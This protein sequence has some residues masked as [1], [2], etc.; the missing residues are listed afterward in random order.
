MN[1]QSDIIHF[2]E[3]A[4]ILKRGWLT[5]LLCAVLGL[6]CALVVTNLKEPVY[7]ARAELVIDRTQGADML[8]SEASVFRTIDET[9][10]QTQVRVLQSEMLV[11]RAVQGLLGTAQDR[12]GSVDGSNESDIVKA[13]IRHLRVSFVPRTRIFVLETKSTDATFAAATAN[14]IASTFAEHITEI[15]ASSTEKVF[16]RL[17]KQAEELSSKIKVM[18]NDLVEF[19]HKS[20]VELMTRKSS[21][22]EGLTTDEAADLSESLAMGTPEI[23]E[24]EDA[25][26]TVRQDVSELEKRYKSKHPKMVALSAEK[27]RLEEQVD[28][29]KKRAFFRWQRNHLVERNAVEFSV[30]ER[31]LE[32]TRRLHELIL[33]KI[34]ELDFSKSTPDVSVR[35]LKEA[36]TPQRPAYPNK[37]VNLSLGAVSG[38]II[39]LLILF[40]RIQASHN[41]VSLGTPAKALPASV[42]ARLPQVTSVKRL[43]DIVCGTDTSSPEA[44]AF[45]ALRT[46][47]EAM[48]KPGSNVVLITSPDRGDGKS[49]VSAALAHSFAM[50]GKKVLLIDADLRRGKLHKLLDQ[51]PGSGMVEILQGDK[52]VTPI[53]IVEN[54]FFIPRGA[55]TEQPSELIVSP[56][57]EELML[58]VAESHYIVILD[59][60]PVL[61]VTDAS[62][63]ARYADSKLMVLRS[64]RSPVE[65]CRV[66]VGMFDGLGYTFDGIIL[67]GIQSAESHQYGR[68]H[69]Y[70]HQ[71]YHAGDDSKG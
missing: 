54:M 22:T 6:S 60:P 66:A 5:I 58:K 49:I 37:P 11:S 23:A 39:G 32:A 38:T 43:N 24:L 62:L 67:N 18:A 20:D 52:N 2:R 7:E 16:L 30:R 8:S 46:A 70:Y 4:R 45:K 25:L 3:Y 21:R 14:A 35:L 19:R 63:L 53:E 10:L 33:G 64:G 12:D 17:R 71:A 68:Y 47:V 40:A 29:L 13:V 48:G 9:F 34:K 59:C 51:A 42:V 27:K 36:T 31:E 26:T 61:P 28:K 41:V 44:E 57:M 69:Y 50:L 15:Y 56:R 1:E 55:Q 65:G